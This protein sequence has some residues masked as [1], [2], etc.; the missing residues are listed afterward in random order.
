MDIGLKL[1]GMAAANR[2]FAE[3]LRERQRTAIKVG[4]EQLKQDLRRLTRGPL[5]ERLAKAWQV[6]F[7]G[8]DGSESPA[9]FAYTKAP[10]IIRGNATGGTVVPIAGS[11]F[12]AIPSERVP[13]RRGRGAKARMSPEEVEAHYN[14]D[15]ILRPGRKPGEIVGLIDANISAGTGKRRA[16]KARLVLMFTFA[17][18]LDQK[19]TIDPDA[20]MRRA[21][22]TTKRLLQDGNR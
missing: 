12:L 1:D 14:Q 10:S 13:R 18:S 9:A 15:L 17:K 2:R 4:G 19:K 21:A 6:E 7:Y 16:K 20:A 8:M 3:D 11:E 5:G 22:R